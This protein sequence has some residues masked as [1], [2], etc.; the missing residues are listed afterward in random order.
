MASTPRS[1]LSPPG[2]LPVKGKSTSWEIWPTNEGQS[3]NFR[4][5]FEGTQ[6]EVIAEMRRIKHDLKHLFNRPNA[7]DTKLGMRPVNQGD[8]GCKASGRIENVRIELETCA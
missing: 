3:M 2:T 6:E 7:K 4:Y 5:K 1:K 8:F